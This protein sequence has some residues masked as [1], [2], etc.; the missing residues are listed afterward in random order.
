[1][2]DELCLLGTSEIGIQ[3]AGTVLQSCQSSMNLANF[4]S[5]SMVSFAPGSRI[6]H[7]IRDSLIFA[8][9]IAFLISSTLL[10]SIWKITYRQGLSSSCSHW[11]VTLLCFPDSTACSI[12]SSNPF[13]TVDVQQLQ[14]CWGMSHNSL[15]N[16]KVHS[17]SLS[18][19]LQEASTARRRLMPLF[20]GARKFAV[21]IFGGRGLLIFRTDYMTYFVYSFSMCS[22]WHDLR[23]FSSWTHVRSHHHFCRWLSCV[24]Y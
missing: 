3:R 23:R 10:L 16:A 9:I 20:A 24:D 2:C 11:G 21:S 14:V 12:C 18:L 6:A 8:V 13:W 15:V 22:R 17:A 4:L 1:M 19:A 7:I 5:G